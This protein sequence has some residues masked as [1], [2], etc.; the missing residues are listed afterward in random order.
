[1]LTAKE[2][3]T[4]NKYREELSLPK[5]KFYLYYGLPFGVFLVILNL[6]LDVLF[7][8]VTFSEIFRKRI[9]IWLATIPLAGYLYGFIVRWIYF[10]HYMKLKEKK[11]SS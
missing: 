1:M 8:G 9:G 3:K 6:T 10:K 11:A 4:F 5:W 2:E 7:N